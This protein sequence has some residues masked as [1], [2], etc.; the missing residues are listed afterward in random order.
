MPES[1]G[2]WVVRESIRGIRW[3]WFQASDPQSS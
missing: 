3:K 2:V 1:G